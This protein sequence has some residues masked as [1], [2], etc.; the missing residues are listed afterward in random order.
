MAIQLVFFSLLFF[1]SLAIAWQDFKSRL[2]SVWLI[3]VFFAITTGN[4]LYSTGWLPILFNFLGTLLY[5]GLTFLVI[6]LYYFLKEKKWPK[7]INEKIGWADIWIFLAIGI[8]LN[9]IELILFF[10]GAFIISALIGLLLLRQNKTVP[11]AGILV[12]LYNFFF[13]ILTI[14]HLD[15]VV[16]NGLG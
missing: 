9:I 10:T 13:C 8:N 15:L 3:I 5:F 14:F 4:T 2:V 16:L 11:L 1:I 12:I 6:Y 7:I